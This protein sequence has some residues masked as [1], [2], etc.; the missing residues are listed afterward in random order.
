MPV[1]AVVDSNIW[2][3]ALITAGNAKKLVEAWLSEWLFVVVY[4]QALITELK[5]VPSKARLAQ[6]IHLED[7]GNLIALIEEDGL[8]I[9]LLDA[10]AVSRDPT[11]DVFLACALA[12]NADYLVTGDKD[13]LCL[14]QK[15][16]TRIVTAAEFLKVLERR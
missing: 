14:K 5:N 4:P 6:R 7:L 11:D 9:D 13:L 8:L 16:S 1:K 3:S 10:P 15:G 12:A 2:I